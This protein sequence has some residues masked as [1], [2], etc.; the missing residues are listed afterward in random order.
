M[1][2][3]YFLLLLSACGK[4]P[5]SDAFLSDS[6]YC[7]MNTTQLDSRI[8]KGIESTRTL[9]GNYPNQQA[10]SVQY[11]SSPGGE[12]QVWGIAAKVG[13][14]TGQTPSA[15]TM[16]MYEQDFAV[17]RLP[18]STD[19]IILPDNA[20]GVKLESVQIAAEKISVGK[21]DW[22]IWYLD[23]IFT[24]LNS[25]NRWITIKPAYATTHPTPMLG[26]FDAGS[27]GFYSYSLTT[28]QWQYGSTGLMVQALIC[29]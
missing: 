15:L 25:T 1:K 13:V 3:T 14:P 4:A 10:L 22:V 26:S 2:L 20:T 5:K 7:K 8:P 19:R 9:P 18:T 11:L 24:I 16:E 29:E 21:Q 23:E 17:G 6:N 28:G 12:V 27:S